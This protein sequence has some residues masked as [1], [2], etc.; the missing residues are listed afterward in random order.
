MGVRGLHTWVER[1]LQPQ[2]MLPLTELWREAEPSC[3]NRTTV[4]VDG[5]ALIRRMYSRDLDWVGG[6]QF[7]ALLLNVH[8]FVECFA[9]C[10]LK[11]V[12]FFDGGVDEAKL[13]EWVSRRR[14]ELRRCEQVA[15]ALAEGRAPDPKWWA[16]PLHISKV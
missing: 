12:C 9:R 6:G 8:R 10:G 16:P 7:Q 14:D 5:M 1:K 3:Q 2:Q 13:R 4:V 15:Q 11:L